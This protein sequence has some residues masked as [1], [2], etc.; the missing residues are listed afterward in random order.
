MKLAFCMFKYFQFGGLQRDFKAIVKLCLARGHQVDVY[1]LEWIGEPIENV[2]IHIIKRKG[3]TNHRCYWNFSKMVVNEL[4]QKGYDAI[5]GFN[6]L[7]GLDVYY[8]ADPCFLEVVG[9]SKKPFAKINPRY[10]YFSKLEKAIFSPESSTQI[11]AL[12]EKQI[13]TFYQYYHTPRERF[14]LLPPWLGDDRF[15]PENIEEI[16]NEFKKQFKLSET[17]KLILFVGSGF[18]IKGLDRALK[19]IASLPQAVKQTV[20]FYIIGDDKQDAFMQ[21]A[22]QLNLAEQVHFLGGRNDIPRFMFSADLLLHPAYAELG[23][24]VL[25]EAIVAGLPVLTTDRCG[26]SFH[27]KKAQAGIV[28][29]SPFS[30]EQLNNSLF[31]MLTDNAQAKVWKHNGLTYQTQCNFRG[32][33][34]IA[35]DIIESAAQNIKDNTLSNS[36]HT[37]Y[38]IYPELQ[39]CFSKID[40]FDA[41]MA[42][43]GEIYRELD[44]RKTLAFMHNDKRYFAKLHQGAGWPEIRK[45]LLQFKIPIISATNEYKAIK[46][47][48][49]LSLH[50]TPVVGFGKSGINPATKRSFLLTSALENTISLEDLTCHWL[51]EPPEFSFKIRLLKEVAK[52][53]RIM[54]DNGINHRDFYIC[55]ILLDQEVL[56]KTGKIKLY[57][58]DLHRAQL[59]KKTPLRWRIKDIAS[60]Y[61]SSLDIGLT[62]NDRFRFIRDYLNMPLREGLAKTS[63][64]EKIITKTYFLTKRS[65]KFNAEL[66]LDKD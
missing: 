43:E 41:V 18:K 11:L 37:R 21:I 31:E 54:H 5:I 6:K 34:E 63:F 17:D 38:F 7:A 9:R 22:K 8:G 35:T 66:I 42:L 3:L 56:S 33:P 49:S 25:L 52:I 4:K 26:F 59:R 24:Y 14:H 32:M 1:T 51:T 55:H 36:H 30:Q 46:K 48:E 45:N 27:V 53:A 29:D 60:I 20:R 58:I 28:L 2:N 40:T 16:R 44:G 64:W 57:V 47:V 50:S 61:Y 19:A 12:T 13:K 62:R 23:G 39:D 65:F 10:H 15:P